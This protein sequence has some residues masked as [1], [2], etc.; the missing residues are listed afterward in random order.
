MISCKGCSGPLTK[1]QMS[2]KT[3]YCSPECKAATPAA[4]K[5]EK[6]T[7]AICPCGKSFGKYDGNSRVY[8][9]E[10]CGK[11]HHRRGVRDSERAREIGSRPKPNHG[12]RGHKQ[13]EEHLIKRLGNTSIRASKE[14]L[15]LV[16]VLAKL[17]YR[18]TG[19]GTFWR[20]WKDGT[21][22][23]PDFVC[24]ATHTHTVV[25]YFGSYWH[26]DDR[27]RENEIRNQWMRIGWNCVIIWSEEREA[28]LSSQAF[29]R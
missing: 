27:G 5:M 3:R 15:S 29:G 1:R 22:H 19:E 23:N 26:A 10:F 21:L 25:E 11:K 9:S 24:E 6:R 14:E 28:L 18:H 17:G 8:C 4:N 7:Q 16:P 20:R 2:S 13:T 12:L